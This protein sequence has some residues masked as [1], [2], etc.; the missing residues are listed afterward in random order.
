MVSMAHRRRGGMLDVAAGAG[1]GI[2]GAAGAHIPAM[3]RCLD[4]MALGLVVFDFNPKEI[5]FSRTNTNVSP[6][7]HGASRPRR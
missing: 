4:P 1:I 3:L 5:S 6:S 7:A 2:A